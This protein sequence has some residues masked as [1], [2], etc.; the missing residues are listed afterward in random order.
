MENNPNIKLE[1]TR[2]IVVKML[3]E[4]LI[5]TSINS[6]A[7]ARN[8]S[9]IEEVCKAIKTVYQTVDEIAKP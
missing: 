5:S 4:K 2:D 7:E 1:I 9:Y 6:T 8:K 3:S